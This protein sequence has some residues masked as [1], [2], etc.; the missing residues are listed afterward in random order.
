MR[1]RCVRRC[2]LASFLISLLLLPF[3][4]VRADTVT[5]AF[6]WP[7]TVEGTAT[8]SARK[9]RAAERGQQVIVVR[10][11]YGFAAKPVAD[12]QLITFGKTQ[13]DVQVEPPVSGMQGRLQQFMLSAANQRPS[14]VIDRQG[15]YLRLENMERYRQ[16][17]REAYA[18]LLAD[19]PD[20]AKERVQQTIE[21]AMS[22]R[23]LE[24]RMAESWNR[25]VGAWVG[26][27]FDR[28]ETYEQDFSMAV[29]LLGNTEVPMKAA[30]RYLGP[31]SC[32]KAASA[33]RCVHLELRSFVDSDKVARALEAFLKR[34]AGQGA[35]EFRIEQLR[36]DT[37]VRLVTEPDTLLP[38]RIE[39]QK[40]SSTVLS[41][42]G[43]SQA[44]RQVEEIV[45]EFAYTSR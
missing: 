4:P 26:G 43:Q 18:A 6:A 25:D 44:T 20:Q 45:Y 42:G 28:G 35:G 24:A 31:V 11:G 14:Y 19:L 3:A 41:Q 23:Q 30:Y 12:G 5:L 36:I 34:M 27:E 7:E 21:G 37:T 15:S 8:F 1:D 13:V 39:Q 10:G 22:D 16:N 2:R 17:L 29:P 32:G 33:D 9:T 38:H 40:V